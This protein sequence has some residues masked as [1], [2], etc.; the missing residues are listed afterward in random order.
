MVG[1]RAS[2]EIRVLLPNGD[3][4]QPEKIETATVGQI[5]SGFFP[6]SEYFRTPQTSW[7]SASHGVKASERMFH[8]KKPG[9]ERSIL[10]SF[11]HLQRLWSEK[12][13][14]DRFFCCFLNEHISDNDLTHTY[15]YNLKKTYMTPVLPR[16]HKWPTDQSLT[17]WN[18]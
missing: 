10:R 11:S 17:Y 7:H 8:V 2:F 3:G 16:N 1:E 15:C 4:L 6:L 12:R 14:H 13:K 9:S 18:S 5:I